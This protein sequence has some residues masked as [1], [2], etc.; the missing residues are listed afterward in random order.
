M[1][2]TT[3]PGD[4]TLLSIPGSWHISYNYAA[5]YTASRFFL[6]LRDEEKILA[7]RCP[8]CART[9]LPPRSYCDRCFRA[10]ETWCEVG[11]EGS[12]VAFTVCYRRSPGIDREPPF[13]IALIR[14]DG[15]DTNL[16]HV[17]EGCDMTQ[18]EAILN[19]VRAG[20]R[21]RPEFRPRD[22]RVGQI[23]D[24]ECFRVLA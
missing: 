14:L 18:P 6:A 4:E 16:I 9:L 22:K 23:L 20:L 15:A 19:Q 17:L 10:C 21:V 7:T 8:S 1:N 12:V 24:I 5:G 2:T 3:K 13:M 11:P